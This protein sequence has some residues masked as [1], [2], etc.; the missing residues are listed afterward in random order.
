MVV[1]GEKVETQD[2]RGSKV[3]RRV[4]C[5]LDMAILNNIY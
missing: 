5:V 2:L 3:G 1:K 4:D